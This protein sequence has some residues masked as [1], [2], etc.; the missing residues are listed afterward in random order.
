M[1]IRLRSLTLRIDWLMILFPVTAA[2]LDRS[3]QTALLFLSLTLHEAAHWAAARLCRVKMTSIRL[4]PFGGLSQI[5]NPYAVSR[6]HISAVAAAGPFANLLVVLTATALLHWLPAAPGILPEL[7]AVNALLMLFNLFP[8]L[9][10]DGGR[11]L[12]AALTGFLPERTALPICLWSGR[13]LAVLLCAL[14]AA[15]PALGRKINLSF[16]FAAAFI[17]ASAGDERQALT[18]SRV[19]ALTDSLRPID[20]PLPA[21]IIAIDASVPIRSALLAARPNRVTLYAVYRN[22]VLREITDD[23]SLMK[24]LI[25]TGPP[26]TENTP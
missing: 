25:E 6:M 4:T 8:A 13:I 24:K 22:G 17:L 18:R 14:G 12:Y 3:R 9:P 15:G 20:R 19:L 5:E 23:R 21:E 11:I 16:L 10:L 7:I 26:L 1:Q 2:L